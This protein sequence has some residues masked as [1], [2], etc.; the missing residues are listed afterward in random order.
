MPRGTSLLIDVFSIRLCSELSVTPLLNHV[1]GGTCEG[2]GIRSA[3]EIRDQRE[4][5]NQILDVGDRW[6][7]KPGQ[8]SDPASFFAGEV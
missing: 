7:V 3:P 2:T 6:I 4:D 8:T 5:L 1:K